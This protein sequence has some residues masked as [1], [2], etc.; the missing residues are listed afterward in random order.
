MQFLN[1]LNEARKN[2]ALN[3]KTNLLQ[4]LI[5]IKSTLDKIPGSGV[6]NGFV[7]FSP[8]EK[9]GVNPKFGHTNVFGI[10]FYDILCCKI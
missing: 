10:Y 1:S 7:T 4:E 8:I 6:T 9:V 3:A 5:S 2:P